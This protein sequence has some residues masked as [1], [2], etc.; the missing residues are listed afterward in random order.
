M[1][2]PRHKQPRVDREAVG[3][4]RHH[5]DGPGLEAGLEVAQV[6]LRHTHTSRKPGLRKT[7]VL[8]ERSHSLPDCRALTLASCLAHV[9]TISA[10][11][12]DV[13]AASGK[14]CSSAR[15]T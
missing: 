2:P 5:V 3:G 9:V 4:G 13:K 8:T 14:I 7:S 12:S 10:G 11:H 1:R 6:R 15:T